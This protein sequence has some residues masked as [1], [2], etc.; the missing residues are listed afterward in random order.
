MG[1]MI[2]GEPIYASSCAQPPPVSKQFEYSDGV[3][4]GEAYGLW[5]YRVR[6]GESRRLALFE[7]DRIWKGGTQ[8]EAI[9]RTGSDDGDYGG[10]FKHGQ[11]DRV[12]TQHAIMYG[13]GTW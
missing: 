2:I 11:D 1:F 13:G 9:V 12:Y 10:Y 5:R 6:M 8:S 7:A 3:F 4:V